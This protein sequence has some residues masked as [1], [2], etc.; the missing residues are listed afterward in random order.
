MTTQTNAK[1]NIGAGA[2]AKS[3]SKSASVAYDGSLTA[4][5]SASVGTSNASLGVGV[6]AKTGTVAAAGAGLDGNNVY[7][8]VSYSDTT[9]I[10][11]TV[12]TQV[13]YKGAGTSVG[14]DAYAKSGNELE[15]HALVGSK[16][17]DAGATVSTGTYVGV[18]A[19]NTTSIRGASVTTGAGVTV[20]DHFEAGGSG[21]ATFIDGK[22]TLGVSGDLAAVV[23]L[24]VDTS[25]TVDTKQMQ[26][27]ANKV[28]NEASKAT[29]SVAS[30]AKKAGND[31]SKAMKKI[32]F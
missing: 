17:V 10:H 25:I 23:G 21:T 19:T 29:N 22:A 11:A 3:D 12:D 15:A 7:A 20:G 16:G 13:N 32:H 8:N 4:S 1:A 6:S 27:D 18:G 2:S 24:K 26:K 9:E 28:A 5:A 14:V 31:V 30:G